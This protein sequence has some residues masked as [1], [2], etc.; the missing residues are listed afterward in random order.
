[1]DQYKNMLVRKHSKRCK[2][3]NGELIEDFVDGPNPWKE[4]FFLLRKKFIGS[5][6]EW[7]GDRR[8]LSI[9]MM[10]I[11]IGGFYTP[12]FKFFFDMNSSGSIIKCKFSNKHSR[13]IKKL[14]KKS[15]ENLHVYFS[16]S[17]CHTTFIATEKMGYVY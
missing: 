5:V 4:S 10:A 2:K 17:K 3:C 15:L 1:M 8:F 13:P 12:G 16:C 11:P 14:Q 9:A 7:Q 6:G